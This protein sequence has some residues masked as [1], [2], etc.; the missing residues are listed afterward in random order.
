MSAFLGKDK[1]I[2]DPAYVSDSDNVGSFVKA[3]SDGQP[4]TWTNVGLVAASYTGTP[5]GCATPVTIDADTAGS[6]GNVTLTG[7]GVKDIATLIS[8]WNTANPTNTL[9]LSAGVGTQVPN[10]GAT[11]VLSGGSNGKDGLDV[12]VINSVNVT[13][14]YEYHE[15]TAHVSGDTGAFIL[16]V[17]N[18]T[19]TALTSANGD[20]SP[21]AVD[22]YGRVRTVTDLDI[23]FDYVYAEDSAHSNGDL[24]AFTLGVRQDAL[25][26]SVSNDGDYGAFKLN[27]RGAMW[28]APVGTVADDVADTENPVKVG[29]RSNWG[30]LDAVSA[31]GDR[32]DLV[33]DKYRRIYVNNGSNINMLPTAR[34][35]T[36]SATALPASAL[37]GRRQILIQNLGSKEMFI[38]DSGVTTSSGLRVAAGATVTLEL[39]SD[40]ALYGIVATGS[41]NVRVL[42]LA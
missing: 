10:N 33:S 4:I 16:A 32:A 28:V 35:V 17:R 7:D 41:N 8:D 23:N 31:D 1:L 14:H 12:Y 15:D 2:Y 34:T 11:I 30:A 18:D 21:I 42:E 38:G 26:S 40:V 6:A 37:D 27:D 13:S 24:G 9:T 36:T 22:Q 39:G 20:Y 19:N 29:S 3:G 25:S 5:T